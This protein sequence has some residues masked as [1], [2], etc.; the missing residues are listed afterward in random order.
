MVAVL[1]GAFLLVSAPDVTAAET[2]LFGSCDI[3]Y[4][5]METSWDDIT[6]GAMYY[7]I[8]G[9]HIDIDFSLVGRTTGVEDGLA[10]SG[11]IADLSS[12]RIHGALEGTASIYLGN[13]AIAIYMVDAVG[14]DLPVFGKMDNIHPSAIGVDTV[15]HSIVRLMTSHIPANIDGVENLPDGMILEMDVGNQIKLEGT[16]SEESVSLVKVTYTAIDGNSYTESFTLSSKGMHSVIYDADGGEVER[17]SDSV[18][19]GGYVQL[20]DV[21]KVGYTF[22]GW[23]YDGQYAGTA[24]DELPVSDDMVLKAGWTFNGDGEGTNWT[25]IILIVIGIIVGIAAF[26]TGYYII[27][28][29]AAVC[30]LFGL[31]FLFGIL[32]V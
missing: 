28:I 19:Y 29:P 13:K 17:T 18:V 1:G 31:L 10:G 26:V 21:Q 32:R 6:D 3:P 2:P 15:N 4:G 20:P 14:K 30:I 11:L 7:V 8:K 24:G 12:K 5:G 25:A 16:P 23:Y 27:G 9:G 22:T